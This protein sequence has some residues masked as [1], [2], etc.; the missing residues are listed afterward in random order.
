MSNID[1]WRIQFGFMC[2]LIIFSTCLEYATFRESQ[3]V[4]LLLQFTPPGPFIPL[5]PAVHLLV[6]NAN[7]ETLYFERLGILEFFSVCGALIK[8]SN[9]QDDSCNERK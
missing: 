5:E 8:V 6:M 3:K 4:R 1:Y 7:L 9:I 2:S